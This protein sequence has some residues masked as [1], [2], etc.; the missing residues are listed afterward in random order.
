ML[1]LYISLVVMNVTK[2]LVTIEKRFER[3]MM[4]SI[5]LLIFLLYLLFV[6]FSVAIH[7][8]VSWSRSLSLVK[9]AR[10]HL[11]SYLRYYA[12]LVLEKMSQVSE[13][14]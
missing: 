6:V 4:S 13:V 1:S 3:R 5:I 12:W 11:S 10:L 7:F 14:S 2:V 8:T 9:L